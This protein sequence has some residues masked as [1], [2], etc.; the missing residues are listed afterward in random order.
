MQ[1]LLL[2]LLTF[3]GCGTMS[4]ITSW[5]SAVGRD[6]PLSGRIWDVRRSRFVA[7]SAMLRDLA[8]ARF[9]LLGE[10]HDNP[11]HHAL[12]ARITR[13]LVGGGR[14]PVVAFEMLLPSQAEA[15]ARHRATKPHDSAGLGKAVAWDQSGWPDWTWYEPIAR[16]ALEAGLPIVP[17][18]LE[19]DRA[20]ALRREGVS[21][22]DPAFVRR[23]AFDAPL[24]EDV[25]T[26]MTDEIRDAHCGHAPP[27]MLPGM[28]AVQR[29][30]DAAM[31]DAVAQGADGG[32]LISGAGHVRN[33]RAAPFYL[34][35]LEPTARTASVAFL[36]VES[37]RLTP[38]RYADRLGGTL[39][40][41][42]IW[43]TP[44]VDAEDPCEKFRKALERMRR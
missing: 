27:A 9:V 32:I 38:E 41:D 31:A 24:A 6:H 33:D 43:F 17:A 11:D 35:R 16:V 44:A 1:L 39:P 19:T 29:A 22:L 40:F 8:G 12:Q 36:E 5:Q 14:R 30:R 21:A 26:A 13:A 4:P 42:Y 23:H 34:R 7:E 20:R 2:A 37:G 3:A 10:K 25:R 15:L 18:N 28:I